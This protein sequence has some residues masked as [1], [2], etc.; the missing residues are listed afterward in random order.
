MTLK[1]FCPYYAVPVIYYSWYS[2]I[3]KGDSGAVLAIQGSYYRSSKELEYYYLVRK[4]D[5]IP[6]LGPILSTRLGILVSYKVAL[7]LVPLEL[8]IPFPYFIVLI[9]EAPDLLVRTENYLGLYIASLYK[10]P[11][12][13]LLIPEA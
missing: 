2:S 6:D 1:N 7:L 3:N 8:Y 5:T 13:F 10:I 4:Q 11:D 12:I 9:V